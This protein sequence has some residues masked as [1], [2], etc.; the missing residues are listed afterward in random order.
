M[1]GSHSQW[2]DITFRMGGHYLQ[3]GWTLHSEWVDITFRMGGQSLESIHCVT[4]Y[5]VG[6]GNNNTIVDITCHMTHV[7]IT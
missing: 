1:G 6:L 2:V 5:C 3:N 7:F 4:V